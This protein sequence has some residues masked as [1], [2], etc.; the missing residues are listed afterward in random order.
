MRRMFMLSADG[1]AGRPA[2]AGRGPRRGT[3]TGF[4][5]P[6]S[7]PWD[8]ATGSFYVSNIGPGPI[9][10]LGREPDGYIS[11]LSAA[12]P[13]GGGQ[14][15]HRPALPE[16]DPPPGRR[17]PGGRRRP[18]GGDRRGRGRDPRDRRPRRRSAPSS[19]TTSPSTTAPA[20][21]TSPTPAATPST[22][23]RPAAP[24]PRSGW[25]RKRSKLPTGCTSTAALA[26][27]G[28]LRPGPR[29]GR[30]RRPQSRPHPGRRPGHEGDQSPR[31]HGAARATWTASRSSIPTG[32]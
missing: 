12:R 15:G 17:P 19:P 9:N 18:A 21:P 23:S 7:A 2:A 22:A 32:S 25:S 11:K 20:T 10:P 1:R 3:V 4:E 14:V 29:R 30:P 31:R 27:G 16:G 24:K 28:R 8:G 6:E 5:N 26:D 13:P